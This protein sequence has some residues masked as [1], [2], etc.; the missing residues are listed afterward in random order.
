MEGLLL[1]VVDLLLVRRARRLQVREGAVN[2]D[3]GIIPSIPSPISIGRRGEVGGGIMMLWV[4]LWLLL[5][6]VSPGERRG[7]R[8]RM[9]L[10]L[11]RELGERRRLL[12]H[13][14]NP[15]LFPG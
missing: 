1:L 11:G 6:R 7:R 9:R 10:L 8:R 14:H 12:A 15:G 3:G 2:V 5:E 13:G 4:M